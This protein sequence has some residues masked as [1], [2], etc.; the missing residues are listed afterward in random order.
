[1]LVLVGD[2]G[3]V[4]LGGAEYVESAIEAAAHRIGGAV[5]VRHADHVD[6]LANGRLHRGML[7]D[8]GGGEATRHHVLAIL[9]VDLVRTLALE[10]VLVAIVDQVLLIYIKEMTSSFSVTTH[11]SNYRDET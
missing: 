10:Q 9:R 7:K 5:L 6:D 8:T 3:T 1:M 4:E 2:R 11:S